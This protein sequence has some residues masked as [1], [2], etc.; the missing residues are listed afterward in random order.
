MGKKRDER[1]RRLE[2]KYGR[3]EEE[4]MAIADNFEKYINAYDLLLIPSSDLLPQRKKA[5]K[6]AKK[7]ILKNLRNGNYEKI[8][9]KK[10]LEAEAELHREKSYK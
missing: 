7:E 5:L 8:V 9:K 6:K 1:F 10:Y 3:T 2:E 4:L